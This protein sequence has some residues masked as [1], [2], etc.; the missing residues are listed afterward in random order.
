MRSKH[1][2]M[3]GTLALFTLLIFVV[4]ACGGPPA[5]QQPAD[6]ETPAAADGDEETTDGDD[7]EETE[8][9]ADDETEEA[10]PADAATDD[11]EATPEDEPTE[12]DAADDEADEPEREPGDAPDTGDKVRNEVGGFAFTP[13]E[14]W[15]TQ[16]AEFFGGGATI[17]TPE[18]F[19]V[20]DPSAGIT[21]F[22]GP[23]VSAAPFV[24]EI[25]PAGSAEEWFAVFAE[26]I[27]ADGS[28]TIS[29]PEPIELDGVE[30]L[31]AEMSSDDSDMGAMEGRVVLAELDD[32]RLLQV[33]GFASAEEWDDESFT[34]LLDSLTFFEPVTPAQPAAPELDLDEIMPEEGDEL[35]PTNDLTT[36]EELTP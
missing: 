26:E 33:L 28:T 20:D 2:Q 10:T 23:A 25:D 11:D 31:M 21:I 36:T 4:A 8:R 35:S 17:M 24:G 30:A 1:L 16:S 6:S 19:N 29:E 13:I 7:G 12:T 18:D 34:T 27:E 32:E 22:A 5:A 15:D 3:I 9:A 14:G